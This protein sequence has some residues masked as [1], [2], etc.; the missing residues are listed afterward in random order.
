MT[1]IETANVTPTGTWNFTGATVTGLLSTN[2]DFESAEQTVTADTLLTVAHSLSE[3]PG[4]WHV[5]LRC[6]SADLN[7]TAGDEIQWEYSANS[8]D[9]GFTVGADATNI[10]IVQGVN[11]P[12]FFDKVSFNGAAGTASKWKWVIKAWKTT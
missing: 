1:D 12:V 10:V 3:V 9:Q 6:D 11:M 4:L 5:I 2:P 7:Y 8:A